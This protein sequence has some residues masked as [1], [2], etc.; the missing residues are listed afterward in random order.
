V[1][2][3]LTAPWF[4]LVLFR[5]GETFVNAFFHDQVGE[6]VI[7]SKSYILV[8]LLEY[9]WL[10]FRETFPW[11]VPVALS[12]ITRDT[13]LW[14]SIQKRREEWTF[15]LV[16]FAVTLAIFLGA[17]IARGR[18][19]LPMIPSFS[20]LAGMLIARLRSPGAQPRGFV[21]GLYSLV[22]GSFMLGSVCGGQ[23]IVLPING[24]GTSIIELVAALAII[25]GGA[26]IWLLIR[27]QLV[28]MAALC[29]SVLMIVSLASI[30]AFLTPPAPE[31]TAAALAR[32]V[33]AKQSKYLPIASVGLDK[34]TRAVVLAYCGRRVND[35][36]M[37]KKT[38]EQVGFMRGL[39]D[40]PIPRLVLMEQKDYSA[41][42]DDLS[43]GLR[44]IASR[45]GT[46]RLEIA[47]WWRGKCRTL[48][49]LLERSRVT[50]CLLCYTGDL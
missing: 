49:S 12:L 14:N 35:W 16:W 23:A 25:G 27:Q 29:G 13:P 24:R 41:L 19:M 1:L 17:N 36:T 5:H 43:Q 6:R 48:D 47:A 7:G 50:I 22:G 21:W 42:P 20:L 26:T 8:N 46:G 2:V 34:S 38:S 15:L 33:V 11:I 31:E 28:Q 18:F 3:L 44:L 37:S 4:A 32:E 39:L 30:N 40:K 45:S 10:F 9:P